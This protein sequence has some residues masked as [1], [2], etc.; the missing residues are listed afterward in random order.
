MT[1]SSESSRISYTGS[2]TTGPFSFPYYFLENNDL[3]VIKRTIADSTEVVQTL[4]THYT[5]S[6][7]ANPAGG[8][9]T[10][11]SSLSSAYQLI[12]YRDPDVLQETDYTP[13][14]RFPAAAHETALD[15]LTMIAQRLK[16]LLS[17]TVRQSDGDTTSLTLTLPLAVAKKGLRWNDAGTG[18]A[19]TTGDI[20]DLATAAAASATAAASSATS[21]SSSAST[22]TTQASN[23]S[24]SA[25]NAATSASAASTSETNAATAKTAAETAETNAETAETNAETAETNAAASAAAA[26]ASASAASTSATTA[27]TQAG[28]A[29]TAK[30]N[31]ET[32]ETNAETAE[33]NAAASAAAAA[34]SA[35]TAAGFT[36]GDYG[37]V[38]DAVGTN[39]DYGTVP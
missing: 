21:A 10:L 38:T 34:A 36:N 9:V 14:D 3:V 27:T 31:A 18:L 37:L 29:A 20:D 5:V 19:N 8:S 13:N 39:S 12:I 35:I 26:A 23:A 6:G 11:V 17:R 25:A 2:G 22:A 16:N 33:T 15:K 4:T 1:V 32:A 24:T 7:A 30:T 28:L